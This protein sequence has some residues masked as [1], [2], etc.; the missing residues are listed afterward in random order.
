LL[1]L[2]AIQL[3]SNGKQY[4]AEEKMM[5]VESHMAFLTMPTVE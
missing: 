1:Q 4:V 5:Q 2:D 3:L